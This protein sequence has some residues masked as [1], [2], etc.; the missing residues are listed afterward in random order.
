[1]IPIRQAVLAR[2]SANI[3]DRIRAPL[4]KLDAEPPEDLLAYQLQTVKAPFFERQFRIHRKRRFRAD[5][6]FPKGQL[7]VEVDGGGY[8]KGRHSRGKGIERDAEKSA[9]IAQMP[10]RLMRVT[11]KHVKSGEAV[12]WILK[13]LST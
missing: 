10:A 5:F 3:L 13:A 6:Y 2:A 8:V 11:P 9:Y 4:T 1:V 7:V 12:D